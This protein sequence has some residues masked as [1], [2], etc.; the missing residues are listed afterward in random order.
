MFKINNKII[1]IHKIDMIIIFWYNLY[2]GEK[3]I[4]KSAPA[5]IYYFV[6]TKMK[7]IYIKVWRGDTLQVHPHMRSVSPS[8]LNHSDRIYIHTYIF[9]HIYTPSTYFPPPSF[10]Y[11]SISTPTIFKILFYSLPS[12]YFLHLLY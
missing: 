1:I 5:S 11:P 2:L 7:Q 12:L 9:T 6:C 4:T 8:W 10:L 3:K